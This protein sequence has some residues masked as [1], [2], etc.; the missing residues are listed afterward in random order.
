MTGR[1]AGMSAAHGSV[2]YSAS[3][4][5]HV[6]KKLPSEFDPPY[7]DESWTVDSVKAPHA[8]LKHWYPTEADVQAMKDKLNQFHV[9][10]PVASRYECAVYRVVNVLFAC[11]SCVL[12]SVCRFSMVQIREEGIL[13]GVGCKWVQHLEPLPALSYDEGWKRESWL[14]CSRYCR[15]S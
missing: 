14:C 9:K 12:F 2:W 6:G 5:F 4:G 7:C 15:K 10:S 3:G 8:P 11:L 13:E 1:V